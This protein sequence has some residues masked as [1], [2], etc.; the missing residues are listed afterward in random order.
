ML[1]HFEA[2]IF[3]FAGCVVHSVFREYLSRLYHGP[4][5]FGKDHHSQES[6]G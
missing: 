4:L 1:S 6:S 5:D 2:Q 3:D